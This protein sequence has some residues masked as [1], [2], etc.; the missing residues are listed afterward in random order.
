MKSEIV[1]QKNKHLLYNPVN[2]AIV[3]YVLMISVNNNFLVVIPRELWLFVELFFYILFV[4]AIRH[5][6]SSIRPKHVLLIS[7]FIIAY[8]VSY[9]FAKDT[10]IHYDVVLVILRWCAPLYFLGLAVND[11]QNLFSLFKIVSVVTIVFSLFGIFVL[12]SNSAMLWAYSQDTGY[13]A[14]FPF[15]VFGADFFGNKKK[16]SI[17]VMVLSFVLMLMGGARGPLLAFLLCFVL[18]FFFLFDHKSRNVIIYISVIIILVLLYFIFFDI[19]MDFLIQT[20]S[21]LGISVRVLTGIRSGSIS[22]DSSR[23]Q[24]ADFAIQYIKDH[25]FSGTGFI[26]DRRLIYDNLTV[27]SNKTVFGYYCHNFF[28]EIC[29]QFGLIIGFIISVLFCRKVFKSISKKN[30]S[31]CRLLVSVLLSI[32]FFPLMVSYSY[33][34]HQYF[35]LLFG[36]MSSPLLSINNRKNTR[37]RK[38][39]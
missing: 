23:S 33:L 34:T 22:A 21:S 24:L 32:G 5:I 16:S 36:F 4:R 30:D 9:M 6:V 17:L 35:Y 31:H 38:V 26:N 29:M 1:N 13:Q 39:V 19:I 14:L 3:Y 12:G 20:F 28:L 25:P 8:L 2:T 37:I 10:V 27:D 11:S 7:V 18:E 15:A